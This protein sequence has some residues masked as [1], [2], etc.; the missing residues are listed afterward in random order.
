M[1]RRVLTSSIVISFAVCGMSFDQPRANLAQAES[2][3]PRKPLEPDFSNLPS[4]KGKVVQVIGN[5]GTYIRPKAG[6]PFHLDVKNL[7][8]T[9]WLRFDPKEKSSIVLF[10]KMTTQRFET[11]KDSFPRMRLVWSDVH[12]R[13]TMDFVSHAGISP[14]HVRVWVL[15]ES[16][17][18]MSGVA[19]MDCEYE[20][21]LP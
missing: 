10:G 18:A 4:L 17:D 5:L 12:Y 19:M 7:P 3:I 9:N 6:E 20:G 14:K 13:V 2:T 11:H 21:T 1:S 15:F 16:T 8:K